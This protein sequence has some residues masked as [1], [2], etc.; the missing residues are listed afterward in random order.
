MAQVLEEL[1]GTLFGSSGRAMRVAFGR[2]NLVSER[3]SSGY[4]G[5]SQ[6]GG[7]GGGGDMMPREDPAK[8]C[9]AAR[10]YEKGLCC[11]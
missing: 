7:G 3:R 8:G 6:W 4:T 2:E 9:V 1:S 10:N 5:Y 11:P